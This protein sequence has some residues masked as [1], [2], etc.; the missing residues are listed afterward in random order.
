MGVETI[1]TTTVFNEKAPEL[2]DV[3][4]ESILL[5][6]DDQLDHI[7]ATGAAGRIALLILVGVV[8]AAA[9]TLFARRYRTA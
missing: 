2:Q 3:V 9:M 8:G 5:H 6:E 4:E 1:H 7:P